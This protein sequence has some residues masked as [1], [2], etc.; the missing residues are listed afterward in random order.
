MRAACRPREP[1]PARARAGGD[2][3]LGRLKGADVGPSWPHLP[4]PGR[5]L[6]PD[7]PPSRATS[8]PELLLQ[9]GATSQEAPRRPPPWNAAP[10][11]WPGGLG[12]LRGWAREW[13][14][15]PP[16]NGGP[17]CPQTLQCWTKGPRQGGGQGGSKGR[18]TRP[19]RS[20]AGS[21]GEPLWV[22]GGPAAPGAAPPPPG[23]SVH[24]LTGSVDVGV[25]GL[26]PEDAAGVGPCSSSRG[27]W[28]GT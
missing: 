1:G 25:A 21:P 8:P 26:A 7:E 28:P 22:H 2:P 6:A 20:R 24:K 17:T 11:A 18:D 10:V 9:V 3:R 4:G 23:C 14:G 27:S 13:A 19:R 16:G 15:S 12:T 5:V